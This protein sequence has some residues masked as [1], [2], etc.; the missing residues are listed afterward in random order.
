M[1]HV[2]VK[3]IIRHKR[4]T[5]PA[6]MEKDRGLHQKNN[7]HITAGVSVAIKQTSLHT[8]CQCRMCLPWTTSYTRRTAAP[9]LP[10]ASHC[11]HLQIQSEHQQLQSL[12]RLFPVKNTVSLLKHH[13]LQQSRGQSVSHE[14]KKAAFHT[15]ENV[16]VPSL[17]FDDS[18]SM[19]AGISP[20]AAS[21]EVEERF[22]RRLNIL[23][24]FVSVL[25]YKELKIT[26]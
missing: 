21:L 25:S 13:H 22:N 11:L 16:T 12:H 15:S 5:G 24:R 14:D 4:K 7:S 6:E 23:S 2:A 3:H 17:P 19:L 20:N 26:E 8:Q 1:A 10:A 9:P 18:V